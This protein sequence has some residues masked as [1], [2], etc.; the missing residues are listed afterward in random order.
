MYAVL[1]RFGTDRSRFLQ[2]VDRDCDGYSAPGLF[3]IGQ[4]EAAGYSSFLAATK[5]QIPVIL[6]DR[7][8]EIRRDRS[9]RP[10]SRFAP[11]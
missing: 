9:E 3:L 1:E 2:G 8:V 11:G 7:S 6:Q 10:E 5:S 4:L